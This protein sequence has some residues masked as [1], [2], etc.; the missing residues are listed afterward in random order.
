MA[1]DEGY[2]THIE[3]GR[4]INA[5]GD[6]VAGDKHVHQEVPTT[7][8]PAAPPRPPAHFAGREADLQRLSSLLLSDQPVA[9]ALQGM[10]GIGKTALAQ[11]LAERI[12]ASFPGGVLWYSL[13]PQPDVINALDAWARHADL[14]AD[15]SRLPDAA[16]RAPVVRSMLAKLGRLC[17]I[18]DDVWDEA[19]VRVLLEAVPPGCPILLT[20][21][22]TDLAKALRCRVERLGALTADESIG[23]LENLLG[24][25][26]PHAAAAREIAALTDGLPLA[27]ELVA[28][29]ADSPADLPALA[30]QL[31]SKP[32][33]D[34][35]R[36]PG[37]EIREKSVE[38]C[39]ALSYNALDP[40][41]RRRFRALGVFAPAPFGED[42]VS[43]VWGDSPLPAGEG[44]ASLMGVRAPQ[45]LKTLT[46]RNLLAKTDDG[47]PEGTCT[48]HALL[49]AYALALLERANETA[50]C[51]ARHADY[52]RRFAEEKSWR[53]VE[54]AFDQIAHGWAW[55]RAARPES[56]TD[57]VF[58]AWKF[59]R[60]RGRLGECL[61]WSNAGLA[62]AR[63]T[64]DRKTEGILLNYIALVYDDLGQ[65]EKALGL[66]EQALAIAREVGDR[67]GEGMTL[68]NIGVAL[69]ALGRLPEA[70]RS[71][72]QAV[73]LLRQVQSTQAE[74]AQQWLDHVRRRL[75]S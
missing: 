17:A 10:G 39:L 3:A 44:G 41:A 58:A 70:E 28:G 51:A 25:L 4:D 67:G 8:T 7:P 50:A 60:T 27:L 19:A 65:K 52:Y 15:L 6:F 45:Y 46:R 37:D 42:A 43:A 55:V 1:D 5:E 57:Y 71:L 74:Q 54:N 38:A 40:E 36:L 16:T 68:W 64:H 31:R 12:Q 35:L 18:L 62:R 32:A 26:G 2:K 75:H 73:E 33:L 69:D 72:A 23:L 21:R 53:E 22:D 48:Q 56:V 29:L 11:K 49:R 34:V 14:R 61:E 59:L 47:G 9:I 24:P 66:Y 13:G 30:A 63:E 20:T